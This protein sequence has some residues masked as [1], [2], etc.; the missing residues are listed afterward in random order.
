MF[1]GL[2][3][4]WARSIRPSAAGRYMVELWFRDGVAISCARVGCVTISARYEARG[5]FVADQLRGD[6]CGDFSFHFVGGS[7]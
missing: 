3:G 4:L 1:S 6:H 5:A 7:V 2:E